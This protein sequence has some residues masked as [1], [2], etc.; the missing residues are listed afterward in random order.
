MEDSRGIALLPRRST[1]TVVE[2]WRIPRRS[3]KIVVEVVESCASTTVFGNTVSLC[4]L[5]P[6]SM[7]VF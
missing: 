7:T 4:V 2:A 5:A 3:W 6:F 1:K